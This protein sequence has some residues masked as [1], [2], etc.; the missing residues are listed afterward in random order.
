MFCRAL[1]TTRPGLHVVR[2][3]LHTAGMMIWFVGL[4]IT[5]LAEVTAPGFTVPIFVTIGAALF[6]AEEVRLRRWIAVLIGIAGAMIIIR[7]GFGEIGFGEA[8]FGALCVVASTPF[9]AASNLIAKSLGRTDSA[10]TIVIWQHVMIVT[11]AAPFAIWFWQVP[12]WTE[13]SG[14]LR[15]PGF[16]ARSAISACRVAISLPTLR[17]CSRSGSWRCCGT[18]CSGSSSL[19]SGR[20]LRIF[21]GAAVVFGSALYHHRHREHGLRSRH[22]ALKSARY[23]SLAR[24]VEIA[25]HHRVD[26]FVEPLD[27]GD[28][29]VEQLDRRRGGWRGPP[30]ASRRCDSLGAQMVSSTGIAVWLKS[31]DAVA[32]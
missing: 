13:D 31:R 23:R 6:L 30:P 11:C 27:A 5:P 26:V 1:H 21:I 14:G 32:P 18:R 9:F 2:G 3:A 7:P 10:N 19:T 29:L 22:P 17:Y 20:M 16:A 25:H 24:P 28:G 15:R 4:S 12:D 8:G